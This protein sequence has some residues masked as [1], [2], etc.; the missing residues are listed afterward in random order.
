VASLPNS[1]TDLPAAPPGDEIAGERAGVLVVDDRA[2]NLLVVRTMLEDLGHDVITVRSGE[3]ALRCLLDR[4]FAVVLLDVNMPG[5]DGLETAAYIRRRRRSQHTPI[6]FLTSYVEEMHTA[7]AYALGAVDYMLTPVIPAILRTKVKVFIDLFLMTRQVE[8]QADQRIAFEREQ[9]A[10]AAAE[11]ST[12]RLS[13][14]TNASDVLASSLEVEANMRALARFVVPYLADVSV[15]TVLP[16]HGPAV[17]AE[18]AWA[19]RGSEACCNETITH[20]DDAAIRDAMRDA[21]A[22][23]GPVELR[24]ERTC[25]ALSA[26]KVVDGRVEKL[27]LNLGF[28]LRS[29]AVLVLVARN[30]RLGT[31]MLGYAERGF[32]HSTRALAED[33]AARAAVAID[34]C[35]LYAKVQEADRRKNEFLAMLAHEL[36]NPLA[37]VRNAA[38]M[39]RSS[40]ADAAKLEWAADVIDRQSRQLVRLVDDLLDVARITQGKITLS[41]EPVDVATVVHLAEEMTRQLIETRR[42]SLT[43]RVPAVPLS[44]YGDCARIAQILA[45]LLNNAA[46]YSEPGSN[47]SLDAHEIGSEI[48]F[49]VRDSGIGIPVDL[50]ESIFDLFIQADRS[51]DRSQGGLGIGLT[52]VRNLV[53][54]QGGSVQAHSAGTGKGSE[55]VVRLPRVSSERAHEVPPRP[56]LPS[57]TA[58]RVLVVDDHPDAAES[59]A[60]L[61][62]SAGHQATIA[63]DGPTAI[64][65]A[66]RFRPDAVLLDIGLPGMNGFEVARVLRAAPETSGCVLIAVSGYGQSE[67]YRRSREVGFDHH[68]VKPADISELEQILD[69]ICRD[70]PASRASPERP[71][72]RF[73]VSARLCA[74]S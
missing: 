2:E 3:Q 53:Q 45:N 63:H 66:R 58:L 33:I 36:R 8:R 30:R 12:R 54:M 67:D 52:I 13:F 32:D 27:S 64:A 29:V 6:I 74:N 62:Q 26:T 25:N 4:D 68:L 72:D 50:L 39:L 17:H 21:L 61:M 69:T 34:N 70:Q 31:L 11:E 55:F 73:P 71:E 42:H 40:Q 41:L 16:E 18:V 22:A 28:E 38:Q 47:I 65:V 56:C 15:L 35:L 1:S 43:I 14:L 49:R 19:G 24:M 37:P 60:S 48:E 20:L 7:K 51:L 44:V 9:A 5:M 23:G 59:M 57:R 46:K 10:R